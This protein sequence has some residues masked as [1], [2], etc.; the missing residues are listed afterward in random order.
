MPTRRITTLALV[1]GALVPALLIARQEPEG[2]SAVQG[3]ARRPA[4]LC[5]VSPYVRPAEP[6]WMV[7]GSGLLRDEDVVVKSVGRE[8]DALSLEVWCGAEG[9]FGTTVELRFTNCDERLPTVEASVSSWGHVGPT[10]DELEDLSGHVMV[11]R[12]R[13]DA[14]RRDVD[15][16]WDAHLPVQVDFDLHGT[17]G[18]GE[19]SCVHGSIPIPEPVAPERK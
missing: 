19:P 6:A 4:I 7:P 12:I 8:G 11:T 16:V 9:Y 3:E 1:A 14:V 10:H 15:W 5:L 18:I 2:E 17:N 13:G